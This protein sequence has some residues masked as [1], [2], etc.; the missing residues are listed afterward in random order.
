MSVRASIDSGNTSSY[1]VRFAEQGTG[2]DITDKFVWQSTLDG[3]VYL[4]TLI[5]DVLPYVMS[6]IFD[7]LVPQGKVGVVKVA[8]SRLPLAVSEVLVDALDVRALCP[9]RIITVSSSDSTNGWTGG[10]H[11]TNDFVSSIVSNPPVPNKI[12]VGEPIGHSGQI[13]YGIGGVKYGQL[14]VINVW[15]TYALPNSLRGVKT[16][17]TDWSMPG[18]NGP[19]LGTPNL[20]YYNNTAPGTKITYTVPQYSSENSEY[21]VVAVGFELQCLDPDWFTSSP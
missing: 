4:Y 20:Y 12:V 17:G 8:L 16:G 14:F 2:K 18:F 9:T 7:D 6:V 3:S 13:T 15:S 21:A 19:I 1:N 5:S 11:R 10:A